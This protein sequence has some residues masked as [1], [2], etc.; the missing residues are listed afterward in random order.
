MRRDKYREERS[1]ATE[2]VEREDRR[3]NND[4]RRKPSEELRS[5]C[6]D[7]RENCVRR[8]E[9][10]ESSSRR[11]IVGECSWRVGWLDLVHS[12]HIAKYWSSSF[13][14]RRM[15]P[16]GSVLRASNDVLEGLPRSSLLL[17]SRSTRRSLEQRLPDRIPRVLSLRSNARSDR[18]SSSSSLLPPSVEDLCEAFHR[19]SPTL[20]EEVPRTWPKSERRSHWQE[21]LL[22]QDESTDWESLSHSRHPIRSVRWSSAK[23]PPPLEQS[24]RWCSSRESLCLRRPSLSTSLESTLEEI[25][26][27]RWSTTL[28]SSSPSRKEENNLLRY[29][30][31]TARWRSTPRPRPPQHRR[32]SLPNEESP[33]PRHWPTVAKKRSSLVD[34]TPP[35]DEKRKNSSTDER[36]KRIRMEWQGKREKD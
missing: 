26:H 18:E 15:F 6:E 7:I 29:H 13:S 22:R 30:R 23:H 4:H 27:C 12:E 17:D 3:W 8:C 31:N 1:S 21:I 33:N 34:C 32:R 16:L 28:S 14:L 24:L 11:A 36:E 25:D 10:D 35:N 19:H 2:P 20:D 5:R 9:E